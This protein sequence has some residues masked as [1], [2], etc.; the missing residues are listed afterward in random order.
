VVILFCGC[1]R[2]PVS[3]WFEPLAAEQPRIH[4]SAP[5]LLK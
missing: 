3:L 4:E 5:K 2:S 1:L